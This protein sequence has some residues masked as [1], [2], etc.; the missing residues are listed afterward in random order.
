[1]AR[2]SVP[3]APQ[4]ARLSIEEMRAALPK[5]ERRLNEFRSLKYDDLTDDNESTV[6]DGLKNKLDDTLM[7]IF[8][9]NSTDYNRYSIH[10]LG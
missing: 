6:L 4:P 10:S 2:K 9:A 3:V 1:V 7:E 5:L 8:G